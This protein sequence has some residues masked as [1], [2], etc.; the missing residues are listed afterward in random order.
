MDL[1]AAHVAF[2]PDSCRAF[3][4]ASGFP[5]SLERRQSPAGRQG[6]LPPA[7]RED[8]PQRPGEGQ[9][10]SQAL[11]L[12]RSGRTNPTELL[13]GG[14]GGHDCAERLEPSGGGWKANSRAKAVVVSRP[15]E[16]HSEACVS[17]VQA[18]FWQGE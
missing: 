6:H 15:G 9:T 12:S 4:R 10:F 13:R 2:P 1:P 16:A 7:E 11:S 14:V 17:R 18:G 3:Q 5:R 8:T